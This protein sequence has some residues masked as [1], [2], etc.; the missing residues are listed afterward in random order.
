[1]SVILMNVEMASPR[2]SLKALKLGRQITEKIHLFSPKQRPPP[3]KLGILQIGQA[4][5]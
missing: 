4:P 5:L 2:Q 1:M 3:L